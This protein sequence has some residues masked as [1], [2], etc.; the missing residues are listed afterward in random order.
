LDLADELPDVQFGPNQIRTFTAAELTDV[1]DPDGLLRNLPQWQSNMRRLSCFAWLV[2]T[3][4]VLLP[5]NPG[6]RAL[7]LLFENHDF[8]RIELHKPK[9]PVA[10]EAALFA[11]LL[12]PW[13][14]VAVYAKYEWRPFEVPWVHTIDDDLFARR[15]VVPDA[16]TLNW[17]PDEERPERRLTLKDNAAETIHAAVTMARE[18]SLCARPFAHFFVE[19]SPAKGS[20]NSSPASRC[21]KQP[22]GRRW[23]TIAA[24]DQDSGARTQAPQTELLGGLPGCLMMPQ[25]GNATA[26]SSRSEATFSTVRL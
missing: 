5:G 15:M 4:S 13:E 21:W 22:L 7:P 6:A 10:V 9:F 26:S 11:L 16:N 19:P 23:T 8:D 3:E 24:P 25:L 17:A 1:V 12:V 18:S 14:D 2:V 20:M